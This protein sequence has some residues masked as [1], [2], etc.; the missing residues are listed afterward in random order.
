MKKILS[1][2]L[3]FSLFIT[4]ARAQVMPFGFVRNCMGF[5]R[6]T[7]TDELK[8]KH[9]ELISDNA[10]KVSNDLLIGAAYYSNEPDRTANLGE[11]AVYSQLKNGSKAITTIEFISGSKNESSKNYNDV[12]NQFVNFY[13]EGRTFKSAKYKA[14]VLVFAKDKVYYYFF[15]NVAIPTIVVSNYKLD[16]VYF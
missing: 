9:F 3:F 12:Y 13:K 5:E 8:K 6:S 15:K 14:D 7:V 16:E 4:A 10:Q 1:L 2:L 11:V